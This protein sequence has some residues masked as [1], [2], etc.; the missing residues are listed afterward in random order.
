M[1]AADTALISQAAFGKRKLTGGEEKENEGGRG[2]EENKM[3]QMK[4]NEKKAEL[5]CPSAFNDEKSVTLILTI[6]QWAKGSTEKRI[7]L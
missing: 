6:D 7:L 2:I 4:D 1:L 5:Y 3:V